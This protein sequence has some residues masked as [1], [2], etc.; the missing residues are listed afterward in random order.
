MCNKE[1]SEGTANGT[2]LIENSRTRVTEWR[3][4]ARGDNT[5]WH[6]HEYDYVVV[7][8]SD[9][10]LE[11]HA[12]DGTS[13]RAELSNGIPYFR[14]KGTQHDVVNANDFEFAFIEIEL[15]G[16]ARTSHPNLKFGT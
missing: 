1:I 15:L 14:Q 10:Q 12:A 5:G 9:G 11:L 4:A 13:M 8:L 3:F 16:E 7:P 6:V 2:V